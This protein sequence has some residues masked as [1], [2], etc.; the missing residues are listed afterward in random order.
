MLLSFEVSNFRSIREKQ[1]ISFIASSLK[2]DGVD[3]IASEALPKGKILPAIVIYGANASGKSNVVKALSS[4]LEAIRMSHRSGE[5]GGGVPRTPFLLDDACADKPTTFELNFIFGG[6]RFNYGF[7]FSNEEF[8]A[9]WLYSYSSDTGRRRKLFERENGLYS[10]GRELKGRNQ[11]IKD[12]TRPN[13]LFLSAA[14]QNS[15]EQLSE[16]WAFLSSISFEMS[17]SL[18]S[19]DAEFRLAKEHGWNIDDNVIEFLKKLG[20]G[21][22]GYKVIDKSLPEE[23]EK[24]Q[25]DFV[26]ALANAM[27]IVSKD[28]E[29]GDTVL[30]KKEIEL[31]HTG[32]DGKKCFFPIRFESA[33]T[34]R[35]LSAM[36]KLFNA[37]A[38][39][40][41]VIFDELDLSLHTK[42]AEAILALF[43]SKETNPKGAQLLAT[44]HDT[45]LLQC[46]LLRRDQVWFTE[47]SE[48][49]E[50]IVYPL[51]DISTRRSDDIERGYLQGR[52]G[53]IPF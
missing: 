14:I 15:H 7:E 10:F 3:L 18:G 41:V 22:S 23:D 49:G 47:K 38:T 1:E 6:D 33:G 25:K 12:L 5:P 43:A 13:S 35:L 42:A 44:T 48:I 11:V 4:M 51:T 50:T 20:T 24:A 8:V 9:E 52:Y 32:V 37:L 27:K 17:L 21:V 39:G 40:T 31:E 53:A 45:N 46:L 28:F 19:I 26:K 30:K 29:I 2:D 16:I 34:L 36:P